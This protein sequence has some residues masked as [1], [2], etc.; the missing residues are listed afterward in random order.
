MVN[1]RQ[2]GMTLLRITNNGDDRQLGMTNN[3]ESQTMG[4]DR[5]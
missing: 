3:G 5:Q 1:D 4:N 2:R